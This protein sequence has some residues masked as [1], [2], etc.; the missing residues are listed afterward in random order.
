[1]QKFNDDDDEIQGNIFSYRV[2]DIVLKK[3]FVYK[4]QEEK[5]EIKLQ[6]DLCIFQ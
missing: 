1:M 6:N 4:V 2:S 3:V 5:S